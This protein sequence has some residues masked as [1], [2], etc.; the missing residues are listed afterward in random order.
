MDYTRRQLLRVLV[1]S[2]FVPVACTP[3]GQRPR[4]MSGAEPVE[5]RS[6]LEPPARAVAARAAGVGRVIDVH[7]HFFNA[8]DV[9]VRGFIAES[10]GHRAPAVAR[11]LLSALARIAD[12]IAS[13]APTATE[14]IDFL[15]S[16]VRTTNGLTLQ[17]AQASAQT[18]LQTERLETAQRVAEVIRGSDFERV[19]RSMTSG[20][21][22]TASSQVGTSADQILATV[23]ESESPGPEVVPATTEPG[24]DDARI[25]DGVMGFLYYMLAYR[26]TNVNAYVA[27]YRRNGGAFGI[28][29]V[30][31]SLVDFDR[32]LERLPRSAHDQQ[33]ELHALLAQLHGG[34]FLRPVA[35]YNPWTDIAEN[36][37]GLDRVVRACRDRGFVGV[38][39]YPPMGF[40]PADNA[41]TTVKSKK[42]RPDL[43][44]LDAVLETF[45]NNCAE[46][47]IPVIAHANQ[48]NGRDDEHD[49]FSS[50]K[51]WGAL[52]RRYANRAQVPVI[53]VGH[54]G[55]GAGSTWTKEFADLMAAFPNT[56][57]Y[58]DL[59]Y[60]DELM[61]GS[62][63]NPKCKV[64]RDRLQAVLTAKI[65]TQTVAD[66]VMFGSDWLML[67]Q[68]KKW[69][70]YPWQ[71]HESIAE[72]AP[73]AVGKIFGENA[74]KCFGLKA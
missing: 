1:A 71:L 17:A 59:G 2:P 34:A 27:A 15:R 7:A 73:D 13:R 22:V 4:A 52:L 35:A 31:S 14:E 48:S 63:M 5:I 60:W 8:S 25:A 49:N 42:R 26:S 50:P 10:L 69:A 39:I 68:V 19:Y 66:R 20:G 47:S 56:L 40:M 41:T 18:S 3:A 43:K 53:N 44:R 62:S 58:G 6:I 24:S 29:T 32:W 45:F 30:L 11:P 23:S 21:V 72:I 28:D 67:S 74:E 61:C 57:L 33:I 51:A 55:G 38:K 16:L 70:N 9:P 65:G 46:L 36:G 12:R 37:A 64:A 54:F